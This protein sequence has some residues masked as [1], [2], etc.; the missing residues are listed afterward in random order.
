MTHIEY[1]E[2]IFAALFLGQVLSTMIKARKG[3]TS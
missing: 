1:A 3:A 2:L